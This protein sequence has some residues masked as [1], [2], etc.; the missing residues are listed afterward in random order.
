MTFPRLRARRVIRALA[1]LPL[2]VP[3][4]QVAPADA[5]PGGPADPART[6]TVMTRNLYL[7]S[8]L[9]DIL[10]ALASGIGGTFLN[11]TLPSAI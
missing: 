3:L 2:L 9:D 8:A 5:K 4:T 11:P 10:A 1:V 7:G 6:A